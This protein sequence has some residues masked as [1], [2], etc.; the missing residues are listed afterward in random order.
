MELGAMELYHAT[1]KPEYLSQALE[2]GRR[3]PI[4]PAITNGIRS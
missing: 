1:G 2:Y 4:T 3:E